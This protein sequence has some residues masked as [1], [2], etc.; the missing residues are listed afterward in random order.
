MK[1]IENQYGDGV[2]IK[3]RPDKISARVKMYSGV[4]YKIYPK[5]RVDFYAIN[6]KTKEKTL[7]SSRWNTIGE[8]DQNSICLFK[9]GKLQQSIYLGGLKIDDVEIIDSK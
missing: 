7:I 2:L 8:K 6:E 3:L 4:Y 5:K 9:G 1:K